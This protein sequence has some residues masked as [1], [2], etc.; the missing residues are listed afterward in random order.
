MAI[1]KATIRKPRMTSISRGYMKSHQNAVFRVHL[2][3]VK[4]ANEELTVK[5]ERGRRRD[6]FQ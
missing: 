6:M 4:R 3:I 2:E 1:N 5:I